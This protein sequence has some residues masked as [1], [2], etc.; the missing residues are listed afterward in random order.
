MPQSLKRLG[1][2]CLACAVAGG[3][4]GTTEAAAS[5]MSVTAA[6]Q[7]QD[8]AIKDSS[9]YQDVQHFHA[10]TTAQ[11]KA[12][13]P[14]FAQLKTTLEHG[15]SVV[16]GAS[17]TSSTQKQGQKDWVDGVREV[18]GGVG[19]FETGIKDLVAGNKDSAKAAVLKAEKLIKAGNLL[20]GKG[21]KLL[22]LPTK[23]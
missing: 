14:K 22:G 11:A 3:V 4:I 15:A 19:A 9:T 21:D 13:I 16:A 10:T 1:T 12:L 17:T 7:A 5:G 2:V 6:I 18:A 20:S 23:D 8:K